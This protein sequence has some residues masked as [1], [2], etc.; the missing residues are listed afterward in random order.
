MPTPLVH[1]HFDEVNG[2]ASGKVAQHLK[3]GNIELF[4]F[5]HSLDVNYMSI[6]L[7]VRSKVEDTII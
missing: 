5:E 4:K 7:G 1:R 2:E 3:E 6:K